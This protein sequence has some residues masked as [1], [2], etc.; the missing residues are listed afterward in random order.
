MPG[1]SGFGL[2]R[3]AASLFVVVA[4]MAITTVVAM[5]VGPPMIRRLMDQA[6]VPGLNGVHPYER[7][8]REATMLSVGI[9]L[10]VSALATLSLSYYLSRRV[11][12][13]AT[14]LSCAASAVAQGNYDIAVL[15][16]GLGKE[17]DTVAAA[18]NTMAQRL[19][20]V[21][22]TRRQMLADLA[23]EIRTPESVLEAYMEAL[24]DGVQ[25]LD[26]ETIATLR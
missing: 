1:R 5:T 9:A 25:Q 20:V 17:F 18:F 16:P 21:E 24:E 12:R 15:T 10:A 8:F 3:L 26:A 22:N 23:H 13:S 2:R 7:A 14:A 11:H 4:G 6:I 19:G